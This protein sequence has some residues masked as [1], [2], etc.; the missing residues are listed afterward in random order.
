MIEIH[1]L[2]KSYGDNCVL[3][4]IDLSVG[5][6]EIV[7]I[8]G[9]SG[10]GKSTLLKCL[11]GQES[12][13]RGSV[14]IEGELVNGLD[15]S[16]KSRRLKR[17]IGIVF[18]NFSLM[19][20]RTVYENI[21]LPMRLWHIDQETIQMTVERLAATVGLTDKLQ[22]RPRELSGGQQQRVAIA[23][24]LTLNP[25]TLLCDEATSALDPNTTNS[26]LRLLQRINEQEGIA[27][28][29]VTHQ[30]EV[31]RRICEQVTVLDHGSVVA[32]GLTHEV[33]QRQSAS[34]TQLLGEREELGLL[35][36]DGV[37]IQILYGQDH[38]YDRFLIEM[39]KELDVSFSIIW[40]NTQRYR[41]EVHGSV[42]VNVSDAD[43]TSVGPYLSERH[44]E[45][46][47]V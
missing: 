38:V 46:R 11:N 16:I 33:L 9:R 43:F 30:M 40:A 5:D 3:Q 26:I 29:M 25:K 47:I 12:Y 23:R 18:Q 24:A 21:A 4:G 2:Y 45:W 8:V 10:A 20:R 27:I 15:N 32:S 37:N 34:L 1:G 13:E 42:I 17:N 31:I 44:V 14:T 7:G 39:S 19:K 6:G 22:S 36:E 41:G 35:P 28:I